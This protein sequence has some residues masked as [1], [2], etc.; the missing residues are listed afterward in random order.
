MNDEIERLGLA[1][2]LVLP[3]PQQAAFVRKLANGL[4][5]GCRDIRRRGH[6]RSRAGDRAGGESLIDLDVDGLVAI[7]GGSITSLMTATAPRDW[8]AL[9]RARIQV[10]KP[11]AQL[12]S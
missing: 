2:A 7:E 8:P 12:E 4:P 11:K 9:C 10:R 3:P 5:E 1:R 6:A